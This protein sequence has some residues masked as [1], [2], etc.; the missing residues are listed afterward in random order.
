MKNII[1][2]IISEKI[3]YDGYLKVIEAIVHI[4]KKTFTRSKLE[5][6]DAVAIL[7]FNE[8]TSNFVLVRQFRYPIYEKN[9]EP[10]YEIP[11]GKIDPGEDPETAAKRELV[12][13]I[14]YE[15]KDLNFI[16]SYFPSVG[17]TSEKIYLYIADV[18]NKDKKHEGG[19]LEIEGEMLEVVE[20][21]KDKVLDMLRDGVIKDGKSII[22]LQHF[23]L[24]VMATEI[25]ELKPQKS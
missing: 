4:G 23:I 3:V 17:Y 8:E 9:P 6:Q 1:P 22:A 5:R 24:N 14:G 12:E 11:A 21:H 19:G 7:V 2:T 10:I 15:V 13:E 20:I 25:S 18:E 16:T